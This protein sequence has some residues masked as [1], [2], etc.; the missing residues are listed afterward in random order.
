V[1]ELDQSIS[2]GSSPLK[3][4]IVQRVASVPE[5]AA[6]C[7]R[8]TASARPSDLVSAI[9]VQT[10]RIFAAAYGGSIE[11]TSIGRRGSVIQS[12]FCKSADD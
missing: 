7:F 1:S 2:S 4:Q 9:A 10:S 3:F 5:E 11:F 6:R 12:V 8:S